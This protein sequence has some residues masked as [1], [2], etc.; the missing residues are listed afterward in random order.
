MGMLRSVNC[1]RDLRIYHLRYRS[2][3]GARNTKEISLSVEQLSELRDK[4]QNAYVRRLSVRRWTGISLLGSHIKNLRVSLDL[5][6]IAHYT[7]LPKFEKLAYRFPR[8]RCSF[9]YCYR[10]TKENI[11]CR[12]G[13]FLQ[14]PTWFLTAPFAETEYF[15]DT[16]VFKTRLSHF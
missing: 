3:Q 9:L 15:L 2:D 12:I 14:Y 11:Q 7:L 4:L 1:D 6:Y 5:M 10:A 16:A 13:S 8:N